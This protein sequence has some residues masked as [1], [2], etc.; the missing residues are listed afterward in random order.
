MLWGKQVSHVTGSVDVHFTP[1]VL[2]VI[3][4]KIEICSHMRMLFKRSFP[5]SM[6]FLF[7][8]FLL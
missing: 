1:Q 8:I 7:I 3:Y 4:S 2:D 6:S 5:L